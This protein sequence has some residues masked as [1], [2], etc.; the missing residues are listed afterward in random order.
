MYWIPLL[1]ILAYGVLHSLLAAAHIKDRVRD[2]FGEQVYEGF[3]RL[4]YN[5]VS[6][7]L[8]VPVA[9]AVVSTPARVLWRIPMPWA[10]IM[11]LLQLVGLVA[12]VI[13]V[14]QADPLRFAGLKQALAYLRND[15]LPLP[16]ENLQVS[17]FYGFVRHPLYLFSML[18][19]WPTPVMTDTFLAFTVGATAYFIAGSLLEERRLVA[20]FGS[21]YVRYQSQVPWLLP[22]PRPRQ[23]TSPSHKEQS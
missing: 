14:L 10:A 17:G 5:I 16:P 23:K 6:A 19:M 1:S 11:L 15:P 13:A 22:W 20:E 7:V 8:F 4:G 18:A 12:L 9:M 21:S 3:Y 2:R